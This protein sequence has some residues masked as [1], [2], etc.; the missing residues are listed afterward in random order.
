LRDEDAVVE[1]ERHDVR[2]GAKR[3]EIEQVGHVG[4]R[5]TRLPAALGQPSRQ[6]RH[7]VERNA[8]AGERLRTEALA[9]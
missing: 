1:V 6:G 7:D 9:R 4:I 8:Y 3:D 5:Q 2:D